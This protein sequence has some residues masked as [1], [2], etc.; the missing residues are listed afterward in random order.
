VVTVLGLFAITDK[1][2]GTLRRTGYCIMLLAILPVLILTAFKLATKHSDPYFLLSSPSHRIYLAS[3]GSALLGGGFLRAI[4]ALLGKYLHKIATMVLISF[5]VGIVICN[6]FLVRERNK[7][8]ES[9]GDIIRTAFDGLSDY[10]HQVGE[11]SQIGL[12]YIPNMSGFTPPMVKLSLG[13]DDV[14]VMRSLTIGGK[15]IEDPEILK[16]AEKSFLFILDND[17]RMIDKSLLFRQQLLLNRLAL[18]HPND[19]EYLSSF[20]VV[21]NKLYLEIKQI[22]PP[23]LKVISE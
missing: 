10:R 8:W 15:L 12:I 11:G 18:L 22:N 19:P 20:L 6:V 14:T 16:K 7:L 3:V 9:A 5:L 21:S 2:T 1:S 4:D 23:K 17:G 13:L